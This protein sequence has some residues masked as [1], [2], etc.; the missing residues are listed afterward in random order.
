[1]RAKGSS[2][3][4][5]CTELSMVF[6]YVAD[7]FDHS[8]RRCNSCTPV[9]IETTLWSVV[10]FRQKPIISMRFMSNDKERGYQLSK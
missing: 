10:V 4:V 7:D 9:D 2:P 5:K 8:D 3:Y 1:M 6:R